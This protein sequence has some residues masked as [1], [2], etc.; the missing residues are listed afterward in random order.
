MLPPA[1]ADRLARAICASAGG[2]LRN[3]VRQDGR[4]CT[5][6]TTPVDGFRRCYNCNEH[7]RSGA[8]LADATAFLTYAIAGRQSGYVMRHYKADK[9]VEEHVGVVTV[10]LLLA[11]AKHASCPASLLGAPVTHWATVPSLPARPVEH[12]LR[13]LVRGVMAQAAPQLGEIAMAAA[14]SVRDARALDPGHFTVP[15]G[16]PRNSHV[17]LIDDT[18][19]KGG[20]AQSAASALR[21]AG[22]KT[23]SVMVVA[24]WINEDF[25]DNGRFL[26][27]IA[28]EDYDPAICPWTGGNCPRP[29]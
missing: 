18:W 7:L 16:I 17:L 14:S 4:T 19:T 5:V 1:V 25:R 21:G 15:E 26:R 29:N 12:P 13:R 3:P 22:A 24:R 10:L 27:E 6:C 28:S 8:E 20:H 9:P 2:Y 23:V 11:L